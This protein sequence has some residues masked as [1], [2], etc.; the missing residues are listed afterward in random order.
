MQSRTQS[1]KI[2]DK[3]CEIIPGG[4]NSPVRACSGMGQLPMVIDHAKHDILTDVDGNHYI[5]FCCSWGSLLHGHAHPKILEAVQARMHKG[6]SFG[7]TTNIEGEL[8]QEIVNLIESIEKIRFVSSG[9]EAT[10]SV[11]RLARGFTNRD[12]IIKFSGNYHGHADLFLVQAGSGVFQLSPTSSSAG[13]PADSV[14][15]T[16]S[17]PFND[18]EAVRE[19]FENPK[20]KGCIAG[21]ILEPVAANMGVVPATSEFI[22]FLRDITQK[23]GSLLIFDEV[24]TGFRVGLKGAQ[25][26]YGVKPDLSCFGKIIGG[27]LPAAA[28]GG[29]ADIMNYLAPLGPVYQAGTLS[30]NPLAMEAGLQALK[31]LQKPGFYE[32][33]K[34]NTDL[35]L[36]PIKEIIKM[37]NVNACIQQVGSMFTLF[38]GKKEVKNMEDAKELDNEMFAKFFRYMFERGVYIPPSQ[39][40]AWFISSQHKMENL[41]KTRDIILNFFK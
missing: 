9:T 34:Q 35:F 8:A 25:G 7:I 15:H 28:F 17:L 20:Y 40:E 30:G 41:I 24:I 21:V 12:I 16:L 14:K 5:D 26:M 38:F 3:M 22:N 23:H 39:H 19:V 2:F 13:I 33:L 32:S 18:I 37:N 29:R 1:K 10:M 31:L 6:T 27:G 11:A 4:V 36:Y